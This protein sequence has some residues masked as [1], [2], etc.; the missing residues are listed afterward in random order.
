MRSSVLRDLCGFSPTS[1]KASV[2]HR[3]AEAQY[4][5][6]KHFLLFFFGLLEIQDYNQREK[7]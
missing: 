1:I 2:P 6:E 5:A 7:L 4:A 3:E